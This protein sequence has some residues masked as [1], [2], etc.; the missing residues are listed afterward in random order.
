MLADQLRNDKS[1]LSRQMVTLRNRVSR[2]SGEKMAAAVQ[3]PEDV[4]R[5]LKR[6]KELETQLD[7]LQMADKPID[8][9]QVIRI[10]SFEFYNLNKMN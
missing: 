7:G 10:G 1:N 2:M 5:L 3:P 4:C 9:H 6:I 8:N